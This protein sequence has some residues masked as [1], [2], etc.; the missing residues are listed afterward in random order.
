MIDEV[1]VPKPKPGSLSARM[2]AR[3]EYLQAHQTEIFP[4]PGWEDLIGVELRALGYEAIRQVQ[5]RNERVRHEPTRELYNLADQV[6]LATVGLHEVVAGGQY[7]PIDDSWVA[8]AQRLP[9]APPDLTTRKA[10]LFLVGDKRL[11]F[12]VGDWGE[13]ARTVGVGVDEDVARDFEMTG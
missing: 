1:E 8:L 5:M 7:E 13:W 4:L 6:A 10:I 9:D 3:A 12:L 2:A 11:P